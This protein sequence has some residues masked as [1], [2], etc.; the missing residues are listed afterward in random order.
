MKSIV[1]KTYKGFYILIINLA[2]KYETLFKCKWK[3]L[4]EALLLLID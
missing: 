2:T 3:L 4:Y 1:Y